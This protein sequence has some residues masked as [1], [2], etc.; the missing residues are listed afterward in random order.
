[1]RVLKKHIEGKDGS[2]TVRAQCDEGE[3]MYHLYNLI[4]AGDLVV[5]STV[6]NVVKE[7]KT[8]SVSKSQVR[9][10]LK[11]RVERVEFD[12]EQCSLRLSGRNVEENE[13]VK[14]GQ[15]HTLELELGHPFTIEKDCWDQIYMDRLTDACDP[16]GK[17]ELA[18]VVMQDG[19]AHVCL[20]TSSMTFTKSRI[21]RTVPKKKAGDGKVAEKSALRFFGDILEAV[22]KHVNFSMVKALLIG[23]PGFLKDDF[24]KFMMDTATRQGDTDLLKQRSK[25]IITHATSGHKNAI[26]DLLANPDLFSQLMDV[27]AAQEVRALQAFDNALTQD[28]NR[29]AYGLK[30][31]LHAHEH[32]HAIDQLLITDELFKSADFGAR[33]RYVALTESV[34]AL[35]GKVFIFSSMHV[36][37]AQLDK[38]TGIAATLRFPVPDWDDDEEEGEGKEVAGGDAHAARSF[39]SDS[40]SGSDGGWGSDHCDEVEEDG[41]FQMSKERERETTSVEDMFGF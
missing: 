36:S 1:M 18:A 40:D 11:I 14:M 6:R 25:I 33:R 41:T 37:G 3:D 4:A 38:Y 27:K 34:K 28:S 39:E 29:V 22:R 9:M 12:S 30:H 7:S 21:E 5:A 32:A 31:V 16:S 35:G 8:G 26:D 10:M 20:I 2:G 15:Y 23:S 13:H 17:A 24:V 19:L